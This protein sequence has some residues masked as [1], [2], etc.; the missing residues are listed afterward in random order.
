LFS[1]SE[2]AVRG[3]LDLPL[4]S[5]RNGFLPALGELSANLDYALIE[6][7]DGTARE[8]RYGF[9][10]SPLEWIRFD[11]SRSETRTPPA[12]EFLGN[13]LTVN[14]DVRL[15]DPLRGGTVDVTLVTGGNPFLLPE[16]LK[17]DRLAVNVRPLQSIGLQLNAEYTATATINSVSSI[18]LEGASIFLAFPDRFV[19]D[20]NGALAVVDVRPVNFSRQ[21][22]DRIRY[23]I[24]F[25]LPVGRARRAATRPVPA[26]STDADGGDSEGVSEA[27]PLLA[28]PAGPKPLL[29]V[30]ANHTYVFKNEVVVRPGVDPIDL[31][32][33]GA[34]GFAGGRPRHQLDGTLGYSFGGFGARLTA[35]WRGESLLE[36]RSSGTADTLRFSPLGTV[37][38]RA[39]SEASRLFPRNGWLKATRFTLAVTNLLNERQR[40]E[41]T[42]GNTPLRYQPGYRDALG[43]TIEFE[44]RKVF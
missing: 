5:R 28:I 1:R 13:P 44:V 18:P 6:L 39:F 10:W 26:V 30:S 11:G 34:I 7:S 29:Q 16:K 38:L 22:Q 17:T 21:S 43:R 24:S 12:L 35:T 2:R 27:R 9:V 25:N 31:L 32:R 33:G 20:E 4:A 41:D 19:R 8:L 23:G 3:A 37:S 15:F 42:S 14:P 36:I 40:V